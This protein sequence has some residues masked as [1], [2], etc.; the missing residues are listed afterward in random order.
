MTTYLNCL[1]DYDMTL[2]IKSLEEKILKHKNLYYQGKPE[3][4]DFEY[5]AI[6]DELRTIDPENEILQIVGEKIFSQ[7]KIEHETKMLSLNKTYKLE[8]LL[9]WS[10]EKDVLSTFKIDGSSCSIIYAEGILQ[11]AKTRGDGRFGENISSKVAFIPHVPKV[12]KNKKSLEV[13]GEVYCTEE[14][15]VKL[16][17]KMESM[18]FDKPTSQRNIVAGLLGRKENIELCKYL[19]FQAFE[20]ISEKIECKLESEKFLLLQS[21]GFETPEFNINKSKEDLSERLEETKI[22]MTEGD[23]LIDGLVL[24]YNDLSLHD[25]LGETAHHPRYKM[26]FKFQGDT[27]KTKINSISWQVSRNGYLTPVANVEPVEL[28]GAMVSRVT[29]HNY[30]IVKQNNLKIGDEIEIVRSGEVIPKF[31][32]VS[33]ASNNDFIKPEV[34]PSCKKEVYEE[35][36]RLVCKNSICPDK[37]RDEILNF[38]QKVGIEDLSTKRLEE[39][40]RLG[41]VREISN[42]YE[43][44]RDQLMSMEKVKDKLADK[45]LINIENSK[46]SK[47]ATVLAA[48]GISGG[49]INKCEKI[50]QN[51][52]NTIDKVIELTADDLQQIESFAEKSANDFVNS[53]QSKLP[54]IVKLRSYGFSFEPE[55]AQDNDSN[56]AGLKFCITGTLSMKRSELQK[57]V[58]TNAGILQSGVSKDTDYLVTNDTESTSSKFIK[59]QTLN[60]PIINEESFLKLIGL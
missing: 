44:S 38:I 46:Q 26:A 51:G 45:I 17:V 49:A 37:V 4:S 43:L 47:L 39:M 27:K 12:I 13:R 25:K 6:E 57:L 35:E 9:K 18:G 42:L 50:V 48:L 60:I 40:I 33:I 52:Y 32:N 30:G 24:S 23:Y 3:I 54:T 14:N 1:T 58:K 53:L 59:A 19:S 16:S 10:D 29:L 41:F 34:C 56:I 7:D 15:F 22:F 31:L 21:I 20:L 2:K 28:S 11:L 5:D 36:I 55:L 8:E